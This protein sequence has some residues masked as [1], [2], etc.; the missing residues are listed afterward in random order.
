MPTLHSHTH[1]Q[2]AQAAPAGLSLSRQRTAG[3]IYPAG[4]SLS[5]Q[6]TAGSNSHRWEMVTRFR[7]TPQS[8]RSLPLNP[9]LRFNETQIPTQKISTF[10]P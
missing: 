5:Q 4:L 3:S 6:R 2:V 9:C 1:C 7:T 10:I 8:Q